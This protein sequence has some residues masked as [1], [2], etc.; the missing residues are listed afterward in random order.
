MALKWVEGFESYSNLISFVQHRYQ[1]FVG[2]SST[3]QPGRA[4]GNCLNFNGTSLITPNLGNQG[5]YVVG[6]AFRNV[7]LGTS[8]V[9]MGVLEF[10]DLT[11][12]QITAT[13]N[14]ST[15]LFSVFRGATLLG[16]G[17]FALTTGSW[18]YIEVAV[19][20]DSAVGTV[21]LR[22][23]TV[24]DVTFG[25]GNTQVTANAYA[26]T[27][28]FRGPAAIGLGGAY[29]LDDIY[30]LDST[31]VFNTTFLGDMKVEGVQVIESGNYAQWGVNVPG[32]PN[33]QAVQVLNDGLYTMSNVATQ[34][35][36]F[37]CANLNR[38]TSDIRGVSAVLWT[39]NTD[40]TVHTVNSTVRQ[41]GTDYNSTAFTVMDTATKAY[42]VIWEQDPDT[43]AQWT[44]NGVGTAEFGYRLAS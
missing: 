28:A 20:V 41:G 4:V 14:P 1:T 30:I 25:P 31:G 6:F 8:N 10:R 3:F 12:S 5:T 11:T 39:R 42:N 21:T 18:Y 15:R 19:L 17:T 23:N 37:E 16:T 35:D 36:S 2:P 29:Q 22:V 24:N 27:L 40:S 26:N 34:R 9:N 38:I 32:T 44:V 7:N 43:V 33:F 13:F